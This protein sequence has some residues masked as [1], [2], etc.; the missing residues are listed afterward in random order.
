MRWV[1]EIIQ[2]DFKLIRRTTFIKII[3]INYWKPS[4]VLC[5]KVCF[6][7][8]E[9]DFEE[10]DIEDKEHRI[11]ILYNLSDVNKLSFSFKNTGLVCGDELSIEP[12]QGTI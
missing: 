10:V 2:N 8:E 12:I 9:I 4:N 11:L 5:K 1:F 6:S 7:L 3:S